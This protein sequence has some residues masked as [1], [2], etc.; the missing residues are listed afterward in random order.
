M[1]TSGVRC[2]KAMSASPARVEGEELL[3]RKARSEPFSQVLMSW[4]TGYW[5]R[6]A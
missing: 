1:N 2:F 4:Q 5:D 3:P 6:V